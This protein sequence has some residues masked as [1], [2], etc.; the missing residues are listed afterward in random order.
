MFIIV[1][2]KRLVP[3]VGHFKVRQCIYEY[4][5]YFHF[6]KAF[7]TNY[8]L[9]LD[10]SLPCRKQSKRFKQVA[11]HLSMWLEINALETAAQEIRT[12]FKSTWGKK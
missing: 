10:Y 1:F 12:N 9:L 3:T 7:M 2:I 6:D 4:M 5:I 8:T 11:I